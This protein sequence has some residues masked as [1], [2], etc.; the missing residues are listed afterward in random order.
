MEDNDQPF[1]EVLHQNRI[2]GLRRIS[3]KIIE[4]ISGCKKKI[5][6]VDSHCIITSW[7]FKT[8]SQEDLELASNFG[9]QFMKNTFEAS[10]A[11]RQMFCAHAAQLFEEHDCSF[12]KNQKDKSSGPTSPTTEEDKADSLSQKSSSSER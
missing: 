11:T 12:C 7:S 4:I 8:S 3:E 6:Y 9:E 1:E 5:N 2:N 10:S